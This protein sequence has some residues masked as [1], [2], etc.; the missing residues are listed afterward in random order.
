MMSIICHNI[1]AIFVR[2]RVRG[3]NLSF[4]NSSSYCERIQNDL[5]IN[6]TIY[7]YH[8][9]IIIIFLVIFLCFLQ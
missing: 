5:A 8:V 3:R 1:S 4:Q 2:G 6:S 9:P 7:F